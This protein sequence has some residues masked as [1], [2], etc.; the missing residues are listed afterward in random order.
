MGRF[1]AMVGF[2]L[3]LFIAG[4]AAAQFADKKALTLAEAKKIAAAAMGEVEKN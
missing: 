2:A 1:A 4:D 3:G